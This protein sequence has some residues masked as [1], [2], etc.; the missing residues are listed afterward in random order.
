MFRIIG[1]LSSALLLSSCFSVSIRLPPISSPPSPNGGGSGGNQSLNIPP[2]EHSLNSFN[3]QDGV[4][5]F[6]RDLLISNN[7]IYG[8]TVEGE[9]IFRMGLDGSNL[10]TI[11][12][13]SGG[14][15]SGLV[16]EAGL[17]IS[18]NTLYGTTLQ[19]GA[20]ND[21]IVFSVG[22]DG[23]NF[24]VLHSFDG[25]DGSNPMC[26][27]VLSGN[28][29]YGTAVNGVG[30]VYSIQTDGSDFSV[31]YSFAGNGAPNGNLLLS[32]NTL[33]GTTNGLNGKGSETIFSVGTNGSGFSVLHTFTGGADGYT[34]VGGLVLS[35]TTLYGMT[36][37]GA[38][39]YGTI[40]EYDITGSV[41]SVLHTFSNSASDGANPQEGLILS[42][43]TLY[44][45]SSG[46]SNG[47]G[48]VFSIETSGADFNLLY[49]FQ[50]GTDGNEPQGMLAIAGNTL[51]GTT[52]GGGTLGLGTVFS[53]ATAGTGYETLT[54]FAD[55]SSGGSNPGGNLIL[56]GNT[57]YGLT[58]DGGTNNDGVIFSESVDGSN[59][60]VLYSFTGGNDGG[61]P[62]GS[63]ILSGSTLY[64]MTS[65]DGAGG[66]GTIF[67]I[68]TNG[69][70]LTTLYSFTGGND[71][72]SPFG[73]LLLS[74]NTLYGM[75]YGGGTSGDGVIFSFP[76]DGTA[77]TTLYSFTGG[78][79]GGN[80]YGSLILSGSTLYGMTSEDGAGGSGTIF[81]IP[82][83][84]SSLTTLYSFTGG[85][86]GGNPYGSLILSGSTLYGMT[87]GGGTRGD[88]TIFSIPTNGSSLTTLY[89]FTGGSDGANP[90]GSLILSGNTLYGMAS[91]GGTSS[92]NGTLF[93]Y[94]LQ[95]SGL[96]SLYS[97]SG[98]GPD[99]GYPEGSPILSGNAL[100]GMTS[101]YSPAGGGAIFEFGL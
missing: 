23:S 84:G 78:N 20:N 16:P 67:S 43:T 61:N 10:A 6:P 41:F 57:L 59:Y 28:T 97:F 100:L 1:F 94:V 70:S 92:N 53:I 62:S 27:L 30:T 71:G 11:Y 99:G 24:K 68:P 76:V 86:D 89:S 55:D 96:T 45:I 17:V 14:A 82:T 3:A 65:E 58:Y 77:T 81:S 91:S 19:G 69:S 72:G 38:S 88:G 5:S 51:Y 15:N 37:N 12:D 36:A 90:Y 54:S 73:D 64:G 21:G 80:P 42:G 79:D 13:F 26:T 66:S 74:G 25:S 40:F 46:G 35:G 22:I 4:G 39:G 7:V 93:S 63:L 75:T 87:Y 44:G 49:S 18:G 85:N 9:N 8:V 29:L 98:A 34:P 32:G 95:G 83:N 60:T 101:S 31:I 47:N 48:G 33:Y 56:S 52:T 50:T 2:G